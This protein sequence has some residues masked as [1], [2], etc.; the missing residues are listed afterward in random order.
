M[1]HKY[2]FVDRLTVVKNID[3]DG[4]HVVFVTDSG[5]IEPI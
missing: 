1:R 3:K 4:N 2:Q 5:R